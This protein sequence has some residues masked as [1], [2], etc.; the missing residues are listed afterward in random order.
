MKI[1]RKSSLVKLPPFFSYDAI[2]GDSSM[3]LSSGLTLLVD[4]GKFFNEIQHTVHHPGHGEITFQPDMI[5][6]RELCIIY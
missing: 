4:E 3:T 6:V 5:E 2:K 1:P